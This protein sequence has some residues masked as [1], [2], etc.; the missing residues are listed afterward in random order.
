MSQTNGV[1]RIGRKGMVK[2]AIGEDGP[3]FDLDVVRVFDEWAQIDQSYRDEN[4]VIAKDQIIAWSGARGSFVQKLL[5]DVYTMY[6]GVAAPTLTGAEVGDFMAR[7]TEEVDK[8]RSFFEP[9]LQNKPTSPE[10][11]EIRF[12]M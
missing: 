12:Q 1:V 2:F 4:G 5:N 9:R 11:T 7:L 10:G 8:L 6:V 3:P